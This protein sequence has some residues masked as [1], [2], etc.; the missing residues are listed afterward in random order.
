MNTS[1]EK[2]HSKLSNF[3]LTI[4]CL[5]SL[6]FTSILWIGIGFVKHYPEISYILLAIGIVGT[7]LSIFL[8]IIF[9]R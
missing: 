5:L 4:I 8:L 9:K 6:I 1:I 3:Y 7:I 2:S